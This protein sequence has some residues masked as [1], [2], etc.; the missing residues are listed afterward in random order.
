MKVH[1]LQ[2]LLGELAASAEFRGLVRELERLAPSLA[3]VTGSTFSPVRAIGLTA[4]AKTLY[5][6]LLRRQLRAPLLYITSSNREA[7]Q[8][9][10]L[11]NGW[12]RLLGEPEP[13]LIPA[14]DIRPYQGLSPHADISE[15]RALGLAKLASGQASLA[16]LPVEAAASRTEPPNFYRG[17]VRNL[18]RHDEVE[19]EELLEHL[20]AVGYLRHDPVEMAGQFSVRGGIVDVFSPEARRPVR[21]EL[22]GD[23]VDS[24]R[25]FDVE[26]QRSTGVVERVALLPLTEFPLRKNLLEELSARMDG[27]SPGIIDTFVPGE[28]FSGWEFLVPL[29]QPLSHTLL[30]LCPQG[31]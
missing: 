21:L 20:E 19:L 9:F 17:L 18:R 2:S 24:L 8:A 28:P 11:L 25:E 27:A 3:R 5:A 16:V 30:D 12:S 14:H 23:E 1:P 26:T 13:V 22:F 15:K 7:E 4:T 6:I 29:V 31:I 10:D